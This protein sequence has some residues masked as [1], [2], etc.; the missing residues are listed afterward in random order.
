MAT[1]K[2]EKRKA[3]HLHT[4]TTLI[5]LRT[6]KPHRQTLTQRTL[7]VLIHKHTHNRNSQ[8]MQN[9]KPSISLHYV[10]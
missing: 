1:P 3:L 5:F 2:I 4:Y 8:I 10:P 9:V 6:Y 7:A